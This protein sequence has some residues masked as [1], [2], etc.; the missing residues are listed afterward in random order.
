MLAEYVADDFTES[1]FVYDATSIITWAMLLSRLL[2]WYAGK[3]LMFG[4]IWGFECRRCVQPGLCGA[5]SLL[6]SAGRRGDERRSLFL[7][8]QLYLSRDQH[9]EAHETGSTHRH[10]P[11]SSP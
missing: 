2:G 5:R 10:L 9:E 4:A 6:Q 11:A 7:S 8:H 1:L 3:N